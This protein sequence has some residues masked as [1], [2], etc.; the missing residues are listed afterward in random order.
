MRLSGRHMQI[1]YLWP[2]D[3]LFKYFSI[4]EKMQASKLPRYRRWLLAAEHAHAAGPF[5]CVCKLPRF[6]HDPFQDNY[7][8]YQEMQ[9]LA[10][11]TLHELQDT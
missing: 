9:M 7:K 3:S 8:E 5:Y 4:M 2:K 11:W 6:E 1:E 10:A